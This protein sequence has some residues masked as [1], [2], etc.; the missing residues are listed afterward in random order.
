MIMSGEKTE[1]YREITP[2]YKSR[3]KNIF[4]MHP[5][6][7]IPAG[8]DTHEIML[9]NG[10]SRKSPSGIV[11]VSLSIK[12]GRPEWGAEQGKEYFVL[13]IHDRRAA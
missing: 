2:H 6:S 4:C 12:T 3:F 9:R 7:C 5:Y 13:K 1:E 8:G 11:T 10:Y